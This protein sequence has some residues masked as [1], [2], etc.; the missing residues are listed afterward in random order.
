MDDVPAIN[1]DT[2][3]QS[4][5]AQLSQSMRKDTIVTGFKC[6]WWILKMAGFGSGTFLK[7][8]PPL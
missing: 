5:N 8:Q 2:A 6:D 1:T 7:D 4:V 3:T